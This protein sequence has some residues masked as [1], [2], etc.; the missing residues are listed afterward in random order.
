MALATLPM[1]KNPGIYQ[2][3]GWVVPRASLDLFRKTKINFFLSGM[4]AW[5][6]QPTA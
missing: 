3:G 1:E 5:I 6:I 2:T 4:E